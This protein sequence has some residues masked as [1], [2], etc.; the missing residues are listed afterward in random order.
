MQLLYPGG[1]EPHFGDRG[2]GADVLVARKVLCEV[3]TNFCVALF[4]AHGISHDTRPE[5]GKW[6][7]EQVQPPYQL[8]VADE[9]L[10][11]S[12]LRSLPLP[13]R[14]GLERLRVWRGFKYSPILE[15]NE[16]DF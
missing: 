10:R 4:R 14:A 15:S 8:Q 5:H 1:E 7:P 2:N 12:K 3:M 13:N 16:R 11:T 9:M 6:S